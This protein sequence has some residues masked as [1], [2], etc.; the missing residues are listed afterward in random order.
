M[1]VQRGPIRAWLTVHV[2]ADVTFDRLSAVDTEG[3]P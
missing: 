2:A 3:A 1:C